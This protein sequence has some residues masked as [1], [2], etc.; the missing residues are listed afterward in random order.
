MMRTQI[1]KTSL[2]IPV[3]NPSIELPVMEHFYTL[4]GEGAWA[5]TPAYFI[6]LAGCDVGCTWCD[7]KDSWT[8]KREQLMPIAQLVTFV[9]SSKCGRVVIT[10]GEPAIYDL[11]S[12]TDAMKKKGIQVH[13]ETSGVYPIQGN[14]DW[15]SFSPKKFKA[16]L[17]EAYDLADEL[18]IIVF[19]DSDFAWAEMEAS[20]CNSTKTQFFLQAEWGKKEKYYSKIVDFIQAHPQWRLSVQIHKYV[21]IP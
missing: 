16:A 4:Q 19:N 15:V 20:R 13:I 14:F 10:G 12:I 21:N 17:P 18:K 3:F 11:R 2:E 1:S 5:G 7:V 8:V 9:D 6:R